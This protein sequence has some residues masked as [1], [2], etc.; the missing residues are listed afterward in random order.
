MLEDWTSLKMKETCIVLDEMFCENPVLAIVVPCYN[1]SDVLP[2]THQLFLEQLKRLV[3]MRLVS[4]KSYILYVDDGSSDNTWE[5]IEEYS[6]SSHFEGISL[7]RNRGHQ[8]ALL[9]GLLY[10]MNRSDVTISIDCDGQD[11]ISKT[12]EMLKLFHTGI[13]VVYGVRSSRETD[14][15]FKRNSAQLF[16]RLLNSLGAE[17]VY[18]HADYRLLSK[19]A[20]TA[21]AEYK[22][23]N[24]YLRGLV[25]LVGFKSAT[26]E[27]KREE[28]LAGSSHYPLRKMIKLAV[29]GV[30]SLSVKPIKLITSFGFIFSVIGFIGVIWAIV[31]LLIGATVPG[32]A[33]IVCAL[34]IFSG[35]QLLAL[36]VMGEY[37]GRIYL[38]EK[39][40]PRFIIA[41]STFSD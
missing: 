38:E 11:D 31:K 13:D 14:T 23:V 39:H 25:P 34:C 36:G 33:S 2:V 40:R 21:L 5:L 4:D 30:T 9:A 32:W 37:I 26:V 24:L 3:E 18:N 12:E 7:S 29:D 41:K 16:Y 19:R 10:A 15:F 27:Y 28:R 35:V 8:N 17:V 20:L 6:K 22:E 1:E